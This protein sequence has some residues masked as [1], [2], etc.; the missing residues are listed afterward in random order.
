ME[1]GL[2]EASTMAKED[3]AGARRRPVPVR[4]NGISHD[5]TKVQ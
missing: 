2:G 1:Q 4:N 5:T 3:F